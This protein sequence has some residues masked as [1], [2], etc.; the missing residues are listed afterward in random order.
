MVDPKVLI[1]DDLSM[2]RASLKCLIQECAQ[3]EVQE[4]MNLKEACQWLEKGAP[5]LKAIFCDWKCEDGSVLDLLKFLKERQLQVQ[6]YC[7]APNSGSHIVT[8]A[9]RRGARGCLQKPFH[10]RQMQHF[11]KALLGAA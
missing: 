10:R 3:V 2:I 5:G 8:E 9:V 7:L 1:I 6:V 11:R 4:A